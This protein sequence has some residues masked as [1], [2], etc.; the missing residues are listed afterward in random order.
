MQRSYAFITK[1]DS[2]HEA[3]ADADHLSG[4]ESCPVGGEKQCR[5]RNILR[6]SDAPQRRF[7]RQRGEAWDRPFVAVIDP[8]GTV[9]GVEFLADAIRVTRPSGKTDTLNLNP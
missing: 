9:N 3:A 1:F 5:F 8:C 2:D 4:D 7:V 6:R